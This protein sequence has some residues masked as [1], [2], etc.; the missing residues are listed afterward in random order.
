MRSEG[1]QGVM[2]LE[3]SHNRSRWGVLEIILV[4]GGAF[5]IT[6]LVGQYSMHSWWFDGK[7]LLQ[8][9]LVA[10][11]QFA[12]TTVLVAAFTV[13]VK[14]A[15]WKELGLNRVSWRN[16]LVYGCGTGI[17]LL[18]VMLALSWP[19]SRIHPEISP[20]LYETMLRNAGHGISF[21]LL[22]FMGAVLAPASEEMFYRA[23][24]YPFLR[25]VLGRGWGIALGG[26]IFGLAHWDL[27]RALPLAVGGAV[28]CY[29]YDK[30]GSIWVPMVAHG[31][32]N[33]V[34]ALLVL[35]KIQV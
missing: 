10:G 33:G 12:A 6:N 22:F 2:S 26:L 29:V 31:V 3:D 30:T 27:W 9:Y 13:G 15:S 28:L 32:W 5:L 7:P 25:G 19:L 21:V 24:I 34:M 23:M 11:V 20:Q 14:Q 17:F 4:Y 18:L 8:F 35:L 16:L 1:R